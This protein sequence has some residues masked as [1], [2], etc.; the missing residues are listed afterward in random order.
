MTT[1]DL[2][3]IAT[4]DPIRYQ[5]AWWVARLRADDVSELDREA[6]RAWMDEDARHRAAYQR[7][8]SLW[9][10]LGEFA[11]APEIAAR[12]E[13]APDGLPTP[14]PRPP[15]QRAARRRGVR[16]AWGA[17]AAIVLAALG[18]AV[19][20]QWTA[21][22][23]GEVYRTAIGE[24]RTLL[25]ADGSKLD[26]DTGSEVTV[27]FLRDERQ[28]TV[29]RGRAFFRVATE[30]RP[31]V[32]RSRY[33]AV[34]AVGTSFEVSL[35]AQAIDV[36]LYEGRV[37]LLTAAD[38]AGHDVK[39]ASLAPGQRAEVRGHAFDMKP[40]MAA[41][42]AMPAWT[43]GRL[44]FD[45]VPLQEAVDEFNRY[46]RPRIVIGDPAL[47]ALRISGRFRSDDPNGFM[48]ALR[49]VYRV[50]ETRGAAGERVLRRSH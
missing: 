28:I 3:L 21:P 25:L 50:R 20:T 43:S 38:A 34:R 16:R 45:D 13:P 11:P 36:A 33:G 9:S 17:V 42:D 5:A 39:L 48:D 6:W 31:L 23:E 18:M 41:G 26:L 44:Q 12:I 47:A 8:E 22:V 40:G 24:R 35:L 10:S 4:G 19:W 7:I 29:E 15:A 37:D 30:A 32:V 27:R 49:V 1:P 46:S 14:S 2:H